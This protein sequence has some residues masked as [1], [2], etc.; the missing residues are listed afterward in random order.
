MHKC[1]MHL[2][3]SVVSQP[4]RPQTPFSRSHKPDVVQGLETVCFVENKGL[5]LN[6]GIRESLSKQGAAL[7]AIKQAM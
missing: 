1:R 3:P 2:Q 4:Q 7:L 6:A 5:Y